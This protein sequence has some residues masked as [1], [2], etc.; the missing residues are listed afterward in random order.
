[1]IQTDNLEKL[2][3][4]RKVWRASHHLLQKDK[5]IDSGFSQLNH[6][7]PN[8]GWPTSGLTELLCDQAGLGELSLLSPAL[9]QLS[10][11]AGWIIW[12]DPPYT[13]YPPALAQQGIDLRRIVLLQTQSQAEQLWALETLLKA[14]YCHAALFWPKR[15]SPKALRR[16]QIAASQGKSWGIAFRPVASQAHASPAPLRIR[17]GRSKQNT[18]AG[19]E[20]EIIKRPGSWASDAFCVPLQQ[21][22]H[23]HQAYSANAHQYRPIGQKDQQE[24]TPHFIKNSSGDILPL[25]EKTKQTVQDSIG[26]SPS[27]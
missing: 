22:L 11:Q 21:G 26:P 1:M 2:L 27:L 17:L 14:D 18:H 25:K 5:G 6:Q 7:L 12:V 15:Y 16:L 10:Q 19:L 13:P 24:I 8:S 3:S 20:I 23:Q 9:A 4:T